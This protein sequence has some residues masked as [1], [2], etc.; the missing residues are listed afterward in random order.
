[1]R[2][3]IATLLILLMCVPLS[4][5]ANKKIKDLNDRIEELE[6][7]FETQ[8]LHTIVNKDIIGTWFFRDGSWNEGAKLMLKSDRTFVFI[9]GDQTINGNW[10]YISE[11]NV[12]MLVAMGE[13]EYAI[14]ENVDGVWKISMDGDYAEKVK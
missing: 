7:Q 2:K 13:I 1:M 9:R 11:V 6:E 10:T 14:F 5:C 3:I 4:S 12:L 8:V